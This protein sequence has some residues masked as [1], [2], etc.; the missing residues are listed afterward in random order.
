MPEAAV[1]HRVWAPE[2]VRGRGDCEVVRIA[3]AQRGFVHHDQLATAGLTRHV[4]AHRLATAWLAAYLP[5]VYLVGRQT[6]EPLG[7]ETAAVLFYRGHAVLSHATATAL[8]GMTEP[9]AAVT[10]TLVAHDAHRRSEITIHRA[11]TLHPADLRRH[12]G[13]PVTAPARSI[14]DYAARASAAELEQAMAQA[15]VQRLLR[16]GELEA[17]LGRAPHRK[18]TAAVRALLA[19]E[20]D[21]AFTRRE[22]ERRFLGLVRSAQLPA[23]HVNAR[24]HGF[25]VDF[26]WP[27]QRLVVETDGSQFHSHPR[28]F[29][30]DRRRDQILVAHGY[31]V[32]R[33]TWRQLCEEPLAVVARLTMALANHAA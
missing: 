31:R 13:L 17:A 33:V 27:E 4:I 1:A 26:L 22:L 24:L 23:P 28:A 32:I 11:Q 19:T 3:S 29:E 14:I 21:P 5:R 8:W 15:R 18:G 16:P 9:D 25:E 20:R 30:N 6:L 7:A 10:V 12:V 2:P